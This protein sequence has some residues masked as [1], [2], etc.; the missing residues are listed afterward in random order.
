MALRSAWPLVGGC[1]AR[2]L[3]GGTLI[4]RQGRVARAASTVPVRGGVERGS[5]GIGFLWGT[6]LGPE[7]AGCGSP[8]VWWLMGRGSSVVLGLVACSVVAGWW[9]GDWSLVENCT[10]DASICGQVF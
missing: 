3:M 2:L 4:I 5:G 6:L 8:C 1:P 10:V 7:G 9:A